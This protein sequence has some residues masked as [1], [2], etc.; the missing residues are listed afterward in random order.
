MWPLRYIRLLI[1]KRGS[2]HRTQPL[3]TCKHPKFSFI[4]CKQEGSIN[5][6]AILLNT[7]S[8]LVLQID[9][10]PRT[11]G[12]LKPSNTPA[13]ILSPACCHHKKKSHHLEVAWQ[14]EIRNSP[15]IDAKIAGQTHMPK[16]GGWLSHLLVH[17]EDND[18]DVIG[19]DEQVYLLSNSGY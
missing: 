1:M 17:K 3:C 5:T 2:N 11:T 19:P 8:F 18:L 15:K 6:R 10:A 14:P 7:T 16:E 13:L 4:P 9:H 12:V